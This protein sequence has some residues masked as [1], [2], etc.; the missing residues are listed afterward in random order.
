MSLNNNNNNQGVAITIQMP[1]RS[2]LRARPLSRNSRASGTRAGSS[3]NPIMFGDFEDEEFQDEV[4]V[5]IDLTSD[6]DDSEEEEEEEEEDD[7]EGID[8]DE[9]DDEPADNAAAAP[10]VATGSTGGVDIDVIERNT[11]LL[12]SFIPCESCPICQERFKFTDFIRVLRCGHSFHAHCLYNWLVRNAH[13]PFC[14]RHV[15]GN[16]Q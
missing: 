9:M 2:L 12:T 14:R 15:T 7:D 16:Q 5:V 3:T 6:S 10:A 13:C 8:G 11:R 4:E 1:R